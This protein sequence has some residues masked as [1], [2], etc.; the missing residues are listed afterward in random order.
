MKKLLLSI[1]VLVTAQL[2]SATDGQST[3]CFD[4]AVSV[5]PKL[6]DFGVEGDQHLIKTFGVIC[7]TEKNM[8]GQDADG[9]VRAGQINVLVY[10]GK[11]VVAK[12][13]IKKG[14]Y[15]GRVILFGR[16]VSLLQR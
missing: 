7:T 12:Y 4:M 1:A 14:E 15:A 8:K 5:A 9:I 13:D 10:D 16:E 11:K 2:A 3:G 6:G